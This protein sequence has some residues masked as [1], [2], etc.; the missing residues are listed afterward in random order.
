MYAKGSQGE[1]GVCGHVS[2]EAT[3]QEAQGERGV[4]ATCILFTKCKTLGMK[5]RIKPMTRYD[6]RIQNHDDYQCTT[7]EK[8]NLILNTVIYKHKT[9]GINRR[10]RSV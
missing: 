1:S 7:R 5:Q 10:A 9:G 3:T 6:L 4:A 2:H 8:K